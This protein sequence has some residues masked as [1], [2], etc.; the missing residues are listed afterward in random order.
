MTE[1]SN[2]RRR[3]SDKWGKH[4]LDVLVVLS[5]AFPQ[6]LTSRQIA[7]RVKAYADSYGELADQAAKAAF[8]KQF[9]RDR[10]KLA[11]LGIEIESRQPE[12]SSKSDGQDFAS[13]RLRLGDQGL[14]RLHFDEEDMPILAA[15]TFLAKSLKSDADDVADKKRSRFASP[16]NSPTLGLSALAPS[17]GTQSIPTSLAEAVQ[18][19]RFTATVRAEDDDETVDVAYEDSDDL[20]FYMIMHPGVRIL[21]PQAARDSFARRLEAASQFDTCDNSS[22]ST[23]VPVQE[24]I[25]K[26]EV[27]VPASLH[28]THRRGSGSGQS[29]SEVDRRLR[30]MLFLS[31]HPGAEYSVEELADRF[32]GPTHTKDQHEK[33]MKTIRKD[34]NTLTT[35]SDDGEIAGSQFFDIDW[36]LLEEEDVVRADNSLGLDRLAGLT[37][38]YLS[39]LVGSVRY[40]AK[41][42]MLP[43]DQRQAADS[44]YERLLAALPHIEG[45]LSGDPTTLALTGYELEPDSMGKIREAIRR[46]CPIHCY[47]TNGA[48]ER[49]ERWFLPVDTFIDEGAFYVVVWNV[50]GRR[51]DLLKQKLETFKRADSRS[52]APQWKTLRASRIAEVSVVD[53]PVEEEIIPVPPISELRQWNFK[54]GS[55]VSFITDSHNLP[56]LDDLHSATIEPW[57]DGDKVHLR[58]TSDSWFVAFCIAHARHI[59]AVSQGERHEVKSSEDKDGNF[60]ET[61][62]TRPSD[63]AAAIRERAQREIEG[64][65]RQEEEE[66]RAQ[67]E[68]LKREQEAQSYVAH[69]TSAAPFG[70]AA[71]RSRMESDHKPFTRAGM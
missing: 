23:P 19:H 51:G 29:S 42:T 70:G 43:D 49:K 17:I 54:N 68:K 52:Q 15:A 45:E 1:G 40:L 2:G 56:F 63:V 59:V 18:T 16:A 24:R 41:S 9:Q 46:K 6:W 66:E 44:L 30:L 25:L 53:R 31:A 71:A 12:Y 8:A 33:A 27:E 61:V 13:Y 11:D 20:A 39:L 62:E 28:P 38:Q 50:L 65:H 47:Y 57:D 32:I 60:V 7:Q 58:I 37:P 21:E 55:D 5:S 3:F 64:L 35:V 14:V 34:V 67:Q 10:A 26:P 4:E 22:R 69:T 36:D 48:G